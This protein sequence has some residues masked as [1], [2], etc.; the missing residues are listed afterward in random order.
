MTQ[1]STKYLAFISTL[2]WMQGCSFST[3][4]E[5]RWTQI[6]CQ[7]LRDCGCGVNLLLT[8]ETQPRTLRETTL[9]GFNKPF[10]V[11]YIY[12]VFLTH[13]PG[14]QRVPHVWQRLL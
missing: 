6:N 1:R 13:F 3:C 2:H 12:C 4:Q 5:Q 9:G 10:S 8:S 14:A 11:K 7:D